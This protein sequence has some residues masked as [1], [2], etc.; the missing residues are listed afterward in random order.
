MSQPAVRSKM[1]RFGLEA[2]P[3]ELRSTSWFDY[4]LIQLSFSV[5]AGNFLLPALAVME[6]GLS[7]MQA[8][9]STVIGAA[10]AFLFVSLLSLPGSVHGIPAQYAMRSYIGVS[11][12][13]F[14]FIAGQNT[15]LSLLV[16]RTNDWRNVYD[17][18]N[19]QALFFFFPS[20]CSYCR[21]SWDFHGCCRCSRV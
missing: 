15:D 2:V 4:F 8:A 10:L 20:F 3:K 7:V 12:A 19:L 11:G 17:H 16:L 13:R 5:N 18:R 6:G 21:A 14:F 9:V 1:E